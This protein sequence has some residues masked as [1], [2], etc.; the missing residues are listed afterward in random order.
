MQELLRV[1]DVMVVVEVEVLDLRLQVVHY[2]QPSQHVQ[3]MQ[4]GYN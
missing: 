1:L 3:I 4:N 2:I